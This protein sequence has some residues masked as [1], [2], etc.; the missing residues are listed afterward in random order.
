MCCD[1][2][3]S[4]AHE[5]PSSWFRFGLG[6]IFGKIALAANSRMTSSTGL[7]SFLAMMSN[8]SPPTPHEWHLNLHALS[9]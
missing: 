1:S 6:F 9:L 5:A 8:A 3:S 4:E 2:A 7:P